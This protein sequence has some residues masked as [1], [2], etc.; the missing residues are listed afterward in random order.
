MKLIAATILLSLVSIAYADNYVV[1]VGA[2]G[3]TFSPNSVTADAGDTIEFIVVG[4]QSIQSHL[5]IATLRRR[6]LLRF[7]LRPLLRYLLPSHPYL[8][9]GA[10]SGVSPTPNFVITVADSSARF[11]YC[12]IDSHCQSGMVFALNPSVI[13]SHP[14]P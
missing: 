10:W 1:M 3:L 5:T 11:F 13:P 2:S 14:Y 12:T 9:V 7:P 6:I 4:V 8:T